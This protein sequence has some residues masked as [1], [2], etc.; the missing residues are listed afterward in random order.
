ME[1]ITLFSNDCPKCRILKK[2]LDM[3]DIDYGI[4]ANMNTLMEAGFMTVPVLRV[5][6]QYY[7]FEEAVKWINEQ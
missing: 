7:I 4:C 6:D 2:K 5:E 3:A 1:S